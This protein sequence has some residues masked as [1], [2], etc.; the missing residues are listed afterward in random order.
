VP[1][2]VPEEVWPEPAWR[3]PEEVTAAAPP[4]APS[5]PPPAVVV[6]ERTADDSRTRTVALLA[7]GGGT[8]AIGAAFLTWLRIR[9]DGFA[10]PGS[11]EVGWEDSGG[12][13]V[14]VAGALALVV[15][16]ALLVGRHEV[17]LKMALLV[18]G[19]SS[20]IIAVVN[21]A[22]AQS[23]ADDIHA[24]F[25]IPETDVTAQIGDGLYL[26]AVAGAALVTAGLLARPN[27]P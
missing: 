21:M 3:Q 16:V 20:L 4:P 27:E 11:A 15:G 7:L 10:A 22:D 6:A 26:T 25:G 1:Q 2:T 14:V 19:G 18:A 9:I 23:K 24:E 5:V 13:A 8:T 17:W 12:K